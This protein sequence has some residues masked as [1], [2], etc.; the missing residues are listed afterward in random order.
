[1]Y[2]EGG[3]FRW[4]LKTVETIVFGEQIRRQPDKCHGIQMKTEKEAVGG[5]DRENQ[6]QHWEKNFA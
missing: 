4:R 6:A 2:Q 5:R 3:L 1:M